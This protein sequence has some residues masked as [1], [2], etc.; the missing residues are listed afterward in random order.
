MD[1]NTNRQFFK[2][3]L[4][5]TMAGIISKVLSAGYRI[6]LQNIT[7]DLGFYIYQQIYPILGIATMLALYGF[8]T[9]ISKIVAEKNEGKNGLLPR[10]IYYSI[11][12]LIFIFSVSFTVGIYF[13]APIIA[14]IMGDVA[15]IQPLRVS[16]LTFLVIPF[17]ASLRGIF[18]G[19]NNMVPTATSQ[20]MEQLVRVTLIITT[21]IV[22]VTKQQ[23]IYM[24]GT[25]AAIA[26]FVGA[27]GAFLILILFW[28]KHRK[29]L[30]KVEKHSVDWGYMVRIIFVYGMVITINHMLLLLFQ[31]ADAFTLVSNLIKSGISLTEAQA[32]KGIFDR[33]QPLVQLGIVVGSAQ[34]LALLPSI[35]KQR[36]IKD[37]NQ[38]FSYIQSA[39]K[40]SLYLSVGA[41]AG[42][43]ALFPQANIL[44][45]KD[46]VGTFSL[47]IL[48]V[49]IIFASLSITTA[50]ILQGLGFAYRTALIIVFGV[51]MKGLLNLWLV[52]I[53]GITGSACATVV[54]AAS[55]FFLNLHQLKKEIPN[56]KII[57]VP[58]LQFFQA[59]SGM[60]IFIIGMNYF[61]MSLLQVTSRIDYLGYVL[62]NIIIGFCIYFFLL[63][64]LKAFT[65][66]EIQLLPFSNIF[67]KIVKGVRDEYDSKN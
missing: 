34:A 6:P 27:I 60:L 41:A 37:P 51:V 43:I 44:L 39:W 18:Q 46:A 54:G 29:Q 50:T 13:A 11:F 38:F 67:L 64:R 63:I 31:F 49:T 52:P 12:S 59:I 24:I 53:Y 3:A 8:P 56:H 7:G 58:W 55:V 9:A 47:Q 65:I 25:G 57:N 32:W 26:S 19:H 20:I 45:F 48:S 1:Q 14:K 17:V 15:L 30:E 42:L 10:S 22:V 23:S 40:F 2:G 61:G 28:L 4:L 33:G 35:T 16:G 36:L 21:A 62:F 5:I 66:R